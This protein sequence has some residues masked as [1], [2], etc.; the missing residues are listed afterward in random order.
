MTASSG[1]QVHLWPEGQTIVGSLCREVP[2]YSGQPSVST[3]VFAWGVN[4]DRQLGLDGKDNMPSP[5]V[6]ESFLGIRLAGRTFY[7]N[8]LVTGS[9]N[10]LAIDAAGQVRQNGRTRLPT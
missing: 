5:K 1:G 4:E 3:V 6:V 9:R 10:T 7:R 8:P 2:R